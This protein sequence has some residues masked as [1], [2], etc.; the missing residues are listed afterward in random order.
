[1]GPDVA[2]RHRPSGKLRTCVV[3]YAS[4]IVGGCT[5]HKTPGLKLV[6][7]VRTDVTSS[8][9]A[10][11]ERLTRGYGGRLFLAV[12][13][14]WLLLQGGRLVLSPLLPTVRAD[15]GLSNAEAGFAFT[16]LWGLYALLQYP[17]G[18]LSDRLS[19]K[20]LL[21][22]GLGLAAIGFGALGLAGSYRWFLLG[23]AVVGFGVGLYPTSARALLSDLYVERRGQAFGLHTAAGDFGG[24][25]AAG[26]GT[27]V[28]AVATWRWAYLPVVIA[29][30]ALAVALHV[31]SRE[32][33]EVR[34]VDLAIAETGRRL[35]GA[36]QLRGLLVAYVLF[37]FTWQATAAFLPTFLLVEKG[38]SPTIANAGFAAFFLVGAT[39]K[40]IA[41]GLSDRVPRSLFVTTLLAVAAATMAGVLVADAVWL[42]AA[43]VVVFAAGLMA[44]PP[45]LQAYL[46]D[47]F[48]TESMGGDLGGMRSVYIGL[49]SL[50]PTVIGYVT[51]I[52]SLTA[53]F[54]VLVGC[55]LIG[56]VLV[57]VAAR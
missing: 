1:V 11:A 44:V 5:G 42:V 17:S 51:D 4:R 22:A 52:A 31:W 15:L 54:A 26:L 10:A 37:A 8:A 43:G 47:T 2:H 20:T 50:G 35:L 16:M 30:V 27:V 49:G 13:L 55:L 38:F 23:A 36:R 46:M 28:L 39:V 12:S 34:R 25:L 56:A 29:V 24:L 48:S 14:G 21:V 18:R 53:G 57:T 32:A 7:P 41:G 6:R 40:P 45:V 3:E 33:Y 19:R 9:D